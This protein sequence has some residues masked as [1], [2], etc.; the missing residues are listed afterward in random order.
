MLEPLFPIWPS[1]SSRIVGFPPCR[2][3]L[4]QLRIAA[5]LG[6]HVPETLVSND[7]DAVRDFTRDRDTIAK[8]VRAVRVTTS[9]GSRRLFAAALEPSS[10]PADDEIEACVTTYQARVRKQ[11]E[12]SVT[13][14]GESLFGTQILHPSSY[15]DWRAVPSEDVAYEGVRRSTG[16]RRALLRDD[17][18]VGSALRRVRL[19]GDT[20]V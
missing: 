19:C 5:E 1:L 12:L 16:R 6:F 18:P 20:R 4:L 14:I 8:T 3:K 9:S 10:M 17:A 15:V 11:Y 7:A 2:V 13:A